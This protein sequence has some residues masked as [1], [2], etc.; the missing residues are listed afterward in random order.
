MPTGR[1]AINRGERFRS[2]DV[3]PISAVRLP[4]AAAD[5]VLNVLRSGQLAQGVQV[6]ELELR[7]ADLLGVR[8]VVA[9]S[10]GTAALTAAMKSLCLPRGSEVVTSP[11]TFVA[12]VNACLLAGLRVRFSDITL[13]DFNLD[14]AAVADAIGPDT[15]AL[16]PVH[17]FGQMAD[18]PTL[19][20]IAAEQGLE[21]VEDAAQAFMA[22][23]GGRAAGTW[24]TGCFSLYATKNI[25]SGEGGLIST[26]DGERA[27]WLRAYRNQGMVQ[28]YVY[29]M[30]GEN[31]RMTDLQAALVQPQLDVYA[32]N[33]AARVRNAR[34]LREGLSDVGWLT[35]PSESPARGH[36]WH[37]FTVL[38][39]DD[40]P[41]TR[42]ELASGLA[43]RG[44]G[45]G[46]YYPRLLGDYPHI[47]DDP[48]VT[49]G[50]TPN[51]ERAARTCLS[52]PVHPGV[53]ESDVERIVEAVRDVAGSV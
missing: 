11:F 18:M 44:V 47:G 24:G 41:L 50:V 35:L 28:R 4:E 20:A 2:G 12:T 26:D 38:V 43:A 42:E 9:V 17:L 25:T 19:S 40:A 1:R 29:E 6:S 39:A 52:L 31:I 22:S 37:Q 5:S 8:H 53:S 15:R 49:R 33:V 7:V 3:I 51:A 46:V 23:N 16:L 13:D 48:R 10:N 21:L 30:V 14:P 34:L 27:A 32:E 45:S 36:V